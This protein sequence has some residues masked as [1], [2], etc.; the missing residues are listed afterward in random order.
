MAE[1]RFFLVSSCHFINSCPLPP[2]SSSWLS[3]TPNWDYICTLALHA[4]VMPCNY[5]SSASHPKAQSQTRRLNTGLG[6]TS[7]TYDK[8]MQIR[9]K[10]KI[11]CSLH[12]NLNETTV[13]YWRK[14]RKN[15]LWNFFFQFV[16]KTWTHN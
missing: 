9:I 8:F 5:N 16:I 3:L 12:K 10:Q 2:Y 15:I 4:S 7:L 11:N 6:C 14:Q 1:V 13:K